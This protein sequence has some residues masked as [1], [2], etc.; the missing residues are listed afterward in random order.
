MPAR[1]KDQ[2]PSRVAR[3]G[4]A[5]ASTVRALG[6]RLRALRQERGWTLEFAADKADLDWKHLQKMEMGQLNVTLVSLVRLAQGLGV[7]LNELFVT[8]KRRAGPK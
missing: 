5:Y 1:T 2:R 7:P 3:G 6:E 4:R 8:P